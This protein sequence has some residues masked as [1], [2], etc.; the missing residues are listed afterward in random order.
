MSDFGFVAGVTGLFFLIG[1]AF[2]VLAVIATSALRGGAKRPRRKR[3]R[4]L[5]EDTEHGAGWPASGWP[6]GW[7]DSTET[8]W[9][10]PPSSDADRDNN[11][12][13]R[14]PGGPSD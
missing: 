11:S 13:P 6:G 8:G 9:E 7:T 4:R 1:I 5:H 12:P 10:E 14:W 2:A 3:G